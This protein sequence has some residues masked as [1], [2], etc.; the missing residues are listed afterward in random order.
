MEVAGCA[1]PS[2]KHNFGLCDTVRKK[3]TFSSPNR[4]PAKKICDKT[5]YN[6]DQG[7]RVSKKIRRCGKVRCQDRIFVTDFLNSKIERKSK[8]DFRSS[9]PKQASQPA[10]IPSHKPV[11][12]SQIS[13]SWGLHG[14]IRYQSG[15]FPY[16]YKGEPPKVPLFRIPRRTFSDDVSP[17]RFV[18]RPVGV[19]SGQQLGSEYFE[20]RRDSSHSLLGRFSAS[21]SES[22]SFTKSNCLHHR[23]PSETWVVRKSR[24]I[25]YKGNAG[26][27][28]SRYCVGYKSESE[29]VTPR[30]DRGVRKDFKKTPRS[31]YVVLAN[32]HVP[33]RKVRF[34]SV[35][36]P[37]GSSKYKTHTK[38][39]SEASRRPSTSEASNAHA[40]S[41]RLLMVDPKLKNTIQS[42][43]T[44]TNLIRNYRRIRRRMGNST[45]GLSPVGS[46]ARCP[47]RLAYKRKGTLRSL[48]GSVKIQGCS[49]TAIDNGTIRQ[50]DSSFLHPKS[51]GYKVGSAFRSNK[52]IVESSS[53]FGSDS[54]RFLPTWSIQLNCRLSVERETSSRLASQR[55]D[56][57]KDF[58]EMGHTPDRFVRD[59]PVESS[60]ELCVH[61]FERSPR[62][63][64][65]CIQP[66]M[67]LQ[68]SLGVST[69]TINTQS[70][71]AFE[72]SCG[73]IPISGASMGEGILE[74]RPQAQ[75]D[76][77]SLSN[78]QCRPSF[79][80][81]VH[82]L[83]SPD[84]EGTPFR[85][86]EDTG[87]S[88]LAVGLDPEDVVLLHSAWRV[89]T[90][91][92]YG[93]AWKQ[94]VAWCK[95]KEVK[96]N[97]PNPQHIA[98]YLGYLSRVKKLAYSTIL[99][100][101]SVVVT[102]ANPLLGQSLSSHPLITTMLKA[103]SNKSCST[104][105]ITRPKIWNIQDLVQWLRT[106]VPLHDS[107]F[108]ISRHVAL[109][110][111]I[112]SGRRVHDLT[113][114]HIDKDHCE[115]T[116]TSVFFWPS[117][118]SKSDNAKHRQ[119]GWQLSCSGDPA[120]SL[121]IWVK[122]LINVSADRR[123]A[124]ENL[125]NLFISTRGIV[126]PASRAVIAGWLKAP[127]ADLGINCSPGSIRSAVASYNYQQNVPL[128]QILQQGNWRGSENFFKHYCKPVD[129]TR[130][131]NATVLNGSFKAV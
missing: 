102:L 31:R 68:P 67:E 38:G 100:H 110:L 36:D 32:R 103:L 1:S 29:E 97:K 43:H 128:D 6:Y 83:S 28:V 3:T 81:H 109:L 122:C 5:L 127:F 50:Q 54:S 131:P 52:E 55:R 59:S 20:E 119:S 124:R 120:L 27:R 71:S 24:K 86:L 98:S 107:L 125:S 47:S 92:T 85:G 72:Q 77:S 121:V 15:I 118:G 10:K 80:R 44:S 129:K 115:I 37:D 17:I 111:L 93:S 114:L 112:A 123:K 45:R 70:A 79:N 78:I 4:S 101:K 39:R 33:H 35:C 117:F 74:G 42:V 88:D 69:A 58:S 26:D 95:E 73:D 75:S 61:R 105:M 116:D 84:G 89:S 21:P 64:Y 22:P 8:T 99:V 51:G 46:V 82:Q 66:T 126:K 65:K 7:N 91:R 16:S 2:F 14:E 108:Q 96:P 57:P 30:K 63:L 23:S 113:L 34:R 60:S 90:W 40:S 87:W 9:P 94:W 62:L 76:G 53:K 11:S 12:G 104:K 13:S 25:G 130:D 106:H 49:S 56:N 41:Q 48:H 18:Q 19:L